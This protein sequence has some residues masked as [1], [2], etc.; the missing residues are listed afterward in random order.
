MNCTEAFSDYRSL[1]FA[2]A[3]RMLGSVMDAEDM[4]QETFIR[5]EG[6]NTDDVQSPKAYLTSIVTRLSIDHLRSVQV[7][8]ETYVGDWLPEP[9]I[10]D[11]GSDPDAMTSLAESLS[12]AF[13]VMLERLSPVE[14]AVFLLRKVFDYEYAEIAAMVDKSEA[15]CRQIVAR[16]SQHVTDEKIR[17]D[18]SRQESDALLQAFAQACLSGNING[19][20]NLLS[21]DIVMY[22]DGGGKKSAALRPV[23]GADKVTRFLLGTLRKIA[24]YYDTYEF[25]M[26]R[27]NGQPGIINYVDGEVDNTMI[28]E[29]VDGKIH[30]IYTV[31]NPDKLK[32]LPLPS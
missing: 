21:E 13:L 29:M 3:Y 14:R 27:I 1:L 22:S 15:N 30:R 23:I 20:M 11:M 5:C 10:V 16:A 18:T 8:R 6:A 26:A 25:R 31:R 12:M 4:V 32:H 9:L 19:L 28:L 2:I 17:F 7:Q 24:R